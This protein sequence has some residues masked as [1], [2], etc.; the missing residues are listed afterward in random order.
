MGHRR[1]ECSQRPSIGPEPVRSVPKT[2]EGLLQD[3][4]GEGVVTQNSQGN[5]PDGPSVTA[6]QLFEGSLVSSGDA[7]HEN[8]IVSLTASVC[9]A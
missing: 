5:R 1:Q 3:V 8:D 9:S 4:L 2:R 6:K 7:R